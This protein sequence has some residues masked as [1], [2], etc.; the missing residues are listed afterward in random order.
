MTHSKSDNPS[1]IDDCKS[2]KNYADAFEKLTK[3]SLT[4][5]L[6]PL[7]DEEVFFKDPFN[8]ITG[9]QAV[10]NVFEHMFATLHAPKFRVSHMAISEEIGY[11][12]WEFKFYLSEDDLA[13]NQNLKT[14]D[15]VSQI[16]FNAQGFIQKHIDYWDSTEYVYRQIPVLGWMIK[17]I[18]KRLSAS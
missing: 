3:D 13:K 9:K 7:F 2:L 15:G 4:S 10:V 11:L 18:Q 17:Q 1:V 12:H 16:H 6:A 5:E 8:Q 14:I